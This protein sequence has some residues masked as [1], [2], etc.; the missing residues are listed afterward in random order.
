MPNSPANR[1][2]EAFLEI[3]DSNTPAD[4]VTPDMLM[5]KSGVE[6][7]I[8]RY[9]F[10][11]TDSVAARLVENEIEKLK[12]LHP[13][14]TGTKGLVKSYMSF[15]FEH[16]NAAF[17]LCTSSMRDIF[18]RYLTAAAKAVSVRTVGRV[19]KNS[20]A[21][22]GILLRTAEFFACGIRGMI[23][24]EIDHGLAED[25]LEDLTQSFVLMDRIIPQVIAE[26]E[27]TE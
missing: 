13:S 21:D 2:V 7:G 15:V 17:G 19:S 20:E 25:T 16:P 23:L 11:G 27:K 5:Q 10:S 14:E 3:I 12:K 1:V 22:S 8:F 4:A 26:A 18:M 6:T 24:K 9:H